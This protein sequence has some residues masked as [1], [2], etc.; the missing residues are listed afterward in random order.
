MRNFRPHGPVPQSAR[1]RR[2]TKPQ[3]LAPQ[4]QAREWR[5]RQRDRIQDGPVFVAQIRCD[6]V[7]VFR[8]AL[9]GT[10]KLGQDSPFLRIPAKQGHEID[11]F[12]A[13]VVTLGIDAEKWQSTQQQEQCFPP[14]AAEP[15]ALLTA[16]PDVELVIFARTQIELVTRKD[17]QG[18]DARVR[19][20]ELRPLQHAGGR[21]CEG[22]IKYRGRELGNGI[23]LRFRNLRF[24]DA[25]PELQRGFN[26]PLEK[27]D[28]SEKVV[29]VGIVRGQ[30]EGLPQ[31]TS[32]LGIVLLLKCHPRQFDEEPRIVGGEAKSSL[33]SI[34]GLLPTFQS[35]QGGSIGE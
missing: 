11:R 32:G 26:I 23:R 19:S 6:L 24:V 30:L 2:K 33:K 10:G 9:E 4:V 7:A 15:V 18:A 14:A 5:R 35:R 22:P 27:I 21:K 8:T 3:D 28:G 25:V 31:A 16:K 34:L 29:R 12:M 1:M 17:P 13:K 20:Q